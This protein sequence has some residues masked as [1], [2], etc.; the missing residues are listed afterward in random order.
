MAGRAHVALLKESTLIQFVSNV[1]YGSFHSVRWLWSRCW[2]VK[3]GYP[4]HTL[5]PTRLHSHTH[6]CGKCSWSS[7]IPGPRVHHIILNSF[8]PCLLNTCKQQNNINEPGHTGL[9]KRLVS[10][11]MPQWSLCYAQSYVAVFWNYT[12]MLCIS[13][14]M[15]CIYF[16][17]CQ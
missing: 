16:K 1:T 10:M 3:K 17:G 11:V 5:T 2:A 13:M 12:Q 14:G 6:I 15:K 7:Y 9:H 8:C 4:L